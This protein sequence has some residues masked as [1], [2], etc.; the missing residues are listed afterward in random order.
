MQPVEMGER[1]FTYS[2]NQA[3]GNLWH[4]VPEMH[5]CSLKDNECLFLKIWI[6]VLDYLPSEL[7]YTVLKGQHPSEW[8]QHMRSA[9]I[10]NTYD[11]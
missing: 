9:T 5:K 3:Q 10:K 4:L 7:K 8:K 2:D 6:P 1:P 11:L